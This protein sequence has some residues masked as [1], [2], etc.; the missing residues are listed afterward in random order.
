MRFLIPYVKLRTSNEDSKVFNDEE[1]DDKYLDNTIDDYDQMSFD[2][3]NEQLKRETESPIM[4]SDGNT[5]E[6][7]DHHPI[8]EINENFPTSPKNKKRK[9]NYDTED[10]RKVDYDFKPKISNT[11][12]NFTQ[13][14]EECSDSLFLRSLLGDL[15]KLND[16][17]KR[18]FKQKALQLFDEILDEN[19]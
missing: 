12:T 17:Q 3:K 18:K 5:E 4:V 2:Y 15:K 1:Y 6:H 11:L 10:D 13:R 9:F 8:V 7:L 14:E 19:T 16:K